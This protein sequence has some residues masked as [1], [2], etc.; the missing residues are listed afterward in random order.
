MTTRTLA[1]GV[2]LL[3]LLISGVAVA[4]PVVVVLDY[5]EA[6]RQELRYH[7]REG[8]TDALMSM[9]A[10]MAPQ[11]GLAIPFPPI[12][13]PMTIETTEVLPDGSA[14]YAVRTVGPVLDDTAAPAAIAMNQMI[15]SMLG[16][17]GG[18]TTSGWVDVR[19][20]MLDGVGE[21]AGSGE[22]D[23]GTLSDTQAQSAEILSGLQDEM[24]QMSA[25]FPAEAV[26]P[27]ARWQQ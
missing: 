5:G 17:V 22:P 18:T 4:Q 13:V 10:E 9:T 14:R 24:Q 21:L 16:Q 23:T 1:S 26:G 7:Y 25:P 11:P 19:G 2:A 20:Q 3:P 15:G 27:G 12:V 6:P 8:A